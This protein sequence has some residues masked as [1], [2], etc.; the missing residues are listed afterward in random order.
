[1]IDLLLHINLTLSIF[2]D[3]LLTM[4]LPLIDQSLEKLLTALRSSPTNGLYHN[5]VSYARGLGT[6]LA[7]CVG[8]Y[9]CWMMM[10][11]RRGMDVMKML[12]IVGLAICI[13]CS[14]FI[15]D[16]LMVPGMALE[17]STMMMAKNENQKVATL[18]RE[19]A[20]KQQEYV[21]S[22]RSQQAKQAEQKAAQDAATE[23]G[24]LDKI[25]H[26]ID[27]IGISLQ[28]FAKQSSVLVETKISE[29]ANDIIRFIGEVIFQMTYYGILMGQRIF[30]SILRIFCPVMF[31]LSIVPPWRNAWS[32]WISKF[33][34]ISLWGFVVY[35]VVY[36][37]DY[38]LVYNLTNDRTAYIALL[39]N[40]N[41]WNN[42]GALGMQ[43]IGTTCMYVVGLLAGAKILSMVPEVCSW[44]IPGGVASGLGGAASGVAGGAVSKTINTTTTAAMMA[45]PVAGSVA[46]TAVKGAA[47]T[48]AAGIGGAISGGQAATGG[49]MNTL[50][51]SAGGALS[52]M[53]RQ[54]GHD[55]S[56]S[57]VGKTVSSSVD[58]MKDSF[59]RGKKQE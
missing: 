14:S 39:N 5:M 13:Q 35:L 6:L 44:L 59:K 19:V 8:S 57:S 23:D 20:K 24:L 16:A 37:V 17:E 31:A 56:H 9:E 45:V 25:K 1:M 41:S 29:W 22:L 3:Q 12:R 46:G 26:G 49:T 32:Q 36:Y 34:T 53:G 10:L 55:V 54:F 18:E 42:I 21:D 33:L 58:S 11:G 4:G 43:A 7:L 51:G 40:A 52:G 47:R 15:C 27:N 50:K 48:G 2:I 30:L 28:N 38:L